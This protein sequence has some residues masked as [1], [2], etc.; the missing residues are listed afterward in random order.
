MV[1]L[2]AGFW[3]W[4][5]IVLQWVGVV[6]CSE[7]GGH[8]YGKPQESSPWLLSVAS[9]LSFRN[10]PKRIIATKLTRKMGIITTIIIS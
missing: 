1:L 10:F 2:L 8:G 3:V 4:D 6:F 5:D 9:Y 7:L